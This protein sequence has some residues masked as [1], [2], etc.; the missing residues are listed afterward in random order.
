MIGVI[1]G[2]AF[3]AVSAIFFLW[4]PVAD[5]YRRLTYSW[6]PYR[7][8]ELVDLIDMRH[9]GWVTEEEY[10][11]YAKQLGL[12][13]I[14]ADKAWQAS[15]TLLDVRDLVTAQWRGFIEESDVDREL[16]RR[17]YT[18]ERIN[19]LKKVAMFFP[20]PPDLIRFAVRE[21][22]TP[23]IAER[24]GLF[25]DL[26]ERF[27]EEAT[28]AGLPEEQA[29]NFWA[30]HWELPGAMQGYE[31]LHR[32]SPELIQAK[33]EDLRRLGIDPDR[34]QTTIDDL[35]T[36]LR[37]LDVMPYWRDRLIAI[38]Y[39][40][41]TRVDVRRMYRIG[42]LTEEE[43]YHAYL[44]LGYSPEN[45]RRMTE[46]TKRYESQEDVGLTRGMIIKAF[47]LDIINPEELKMWLSRLGYAPDIVDFWAEI[48]IYEKEQGDLEEKIDDLVEQYRLGELTLDEL[49]VK[50]DALG[51]EA[52]YAH[53]IITKELA[54]RTKKLKLPT[55]GDLTDWLRLGIIEERQFVDRMGRLGYKEDDI[56]NYLTEIAL[57]TDTS[58][59]KY[60][61][62]KTYQRWL[63]A[64]L[65]SAE[66]FSR[67]G[68]ELGF[69]EDDIA[70]LVSEV[71]PTLLPIKTYQEWLLKG[72]IT[73]EF[74]RTVARE[75]GIPQP[76]IDEMV[77]LYTPS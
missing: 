7:I 22:Y 23:E 8:P 32:L 11:R 52:S 28:K 29:R 41:L 55:R 2:M 63:G 60:L 31:M 75:L 46:F 10:Y 9:K 35:R 17:G 61:P 59:R 37:A 50:L 16:S 26:P 1:A 64:H 77:R 18:P 21:V 70:R 4:P 36:L 38:S 54:K 72:E 51:I 76:D 65:I 74:F 68:R 57:Q 5:V 34:V 24:F 12:N 20:S 19:V 71:A 47:K 33:S 67:I 53:R 6:W 14:W 49:R 25:Q 15:H 48:A 58:E 13:E 30:A 62:I 43:V 69:S 40:P 44:E 45:A 73:E 56:V 39:S 27:L 42:V 66:T 3:G